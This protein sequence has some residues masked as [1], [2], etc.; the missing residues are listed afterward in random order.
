MVID[1]RVRKCLNIQ[2]DE[3]HLESI[4]AML[5]EK[6]DVY[7]LGCVYKGEEYYANIDT[8]SLRPLAFDEELFEYISH[9]SVGGWIEGLDINR[10]G[11][12]F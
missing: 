8:Y 9:K 1:I 5:P 2:Y 6:N 7:V 10:I 3:M 12:L 4:N 11:D